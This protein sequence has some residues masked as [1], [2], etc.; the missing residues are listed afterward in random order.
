MTH[1]VSQR[2]G[3][4]SAEAA[5]KAGLALQEA[6][7]L[8]EAVK[9]YRAAVDAKPDFAGAF[10]NLGVVLKKLGRAN[11]ALAAY[12]MAVDL[13][14]KFFEAQYNHSILLDL[15]GR[16]RAAIEGYRRAISLRP[17]V[18]GVHCN[19]GKAL[20]EDGQLEQARA[21]YGEALRLQP[22]HLAALLNLAS[23]LIDATEGE[24]ALLVAARALSV[25]NSGGGPGVGH[26]LELSAKAA[27]LCGDEEAALDFARRARQ[28]NSGSFQSVKLLAGVLGRLGRDDELAK[29]YSDVLAAQPGQAEAAARLSSLF[30][31]NG[32]ATEAL[33]VSEKSL[34]HSPGNTRAIAAKVAALTALGRLKALNRVLDLDRLV[35]ARKIDR[36]PGFP[37]MAAFKAAMIEHVLQHPSLKGD[38]VGLSTRAGRQTGEL[39]IDPKGP[40]AAF[41]RLIVE[42]VVDYARSHP[43]SQETPFLAA[44]PSRWS[45]SIWATVLGASGHQQPHLHPSGWL[46]GV[47]YL[48][49]P[50]QVAASDNSQRGWIEFGRP[51]QL[52]EGAVL[53]TLKTVAPEENLLL[54]FPSY[55]HHRTIPTGQEALRISIAFDVLPHDQSQS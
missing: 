42:A 15:V 9:A 49:V 29:L 17:D 26:A 5:F 35:V 20:Q 54:L 16:H 55:L 53:P 25:A 44:Q 45:L 33:A 10:C 34:R 18:A 3:R 19:L 41:E 47:F 48:A 2:D 12:Q 39:L 24:E 43:V 46:S 22:N 23:V 6:G 28:E 14:P 52:P 30:L 4:P 8:Q 11:E 13:E 40:I 32:K 50:P 31:T 51:P 1:G 37:T 7:R 38:P 21:A 36:V 27:L